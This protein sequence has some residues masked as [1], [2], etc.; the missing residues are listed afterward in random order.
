MLGAV[1]LFLLETFLGLFALALLLRFFLQWLRAPVR[2]PLSHFLAA[3]TNWVVLPARRVIPGL[4]G[5]DLAT[6]VLAWA[7][8]V[9]LILATY[10][11]R[12]A[13]LGPAVGASLVLIGFLA[14]VQ[15]AKLSVWVLMVG[16][17][18]QAIL[19]W[20]SPYSPAM[21]LLN[22]LARP[23]LRVFQRRIPPVGS[24]DLSPLF[25]LVTCQLLLFMIAW[26]EGAVG[27]AIVV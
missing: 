3:L 23:F 8:E 18:A 15:L 5:L 12:G 7:T 16:V 24:V 4:W 13:S 21:P 10:W 9:V 1:L 26:V 20:V 22:S 2:N 19:S 6:V 14:V 27:R 17:V 11:I 25:V